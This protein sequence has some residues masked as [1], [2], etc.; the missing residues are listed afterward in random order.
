M[1]LLATLT[2]PSGNPTP[3]ARDLYFSCWI[4]SSGRREI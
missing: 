4:T 1:N 3:P 2:K